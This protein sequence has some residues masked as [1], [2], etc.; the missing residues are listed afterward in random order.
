[1]VARG[2]LV[3]IGG[4]RDLRRMDEPSLKRSRYCGIPDNSMKFKNSTR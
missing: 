1:M 2:P 4:C 3:T